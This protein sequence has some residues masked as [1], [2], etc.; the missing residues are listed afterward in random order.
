MLEELPKYFSVRIRRT[1]EKNI[2]IVGHSGMIAHYNGS[3]WKYYSEHCF[4]GILYGVAV[5]DDQVAAVGQMNY[6]AI[7]VMGTK[8]NFLEFKRKNL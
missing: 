2:W 1:S 3:T 8:N 5:T 7:I 4:N 6:K